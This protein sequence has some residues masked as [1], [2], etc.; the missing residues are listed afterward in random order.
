MP[1]YEPATIVEYSE[2]EDPKQAVF[3]KIL[4]LIDGLRLFRNEVLLVTAPNKVKSAGGIILPEKYKSEQRFQG[5][6]GLVVAMGEL[7]FNDDKLW[8]NPETRPVVGSWVFFRT[9][10]TSECAIGGYSC[11][12]IDDDKVRGSALAPDSLR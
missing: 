8:P 11:R 2:G 1:V 3:D 10:D 4:P 12:F 6:V 5:K 9:A 7:A